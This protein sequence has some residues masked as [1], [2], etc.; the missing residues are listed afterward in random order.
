MQ[1]RR[2]PDGDRYVQRATLAWCGFQFQ[3]S[4][5]KKEPVADVF[6]AE[7][8][9]L[10]FWI[11]PFSVITDVDHKL[12]GGTKELQ[13]HIPAGGMP[14]NVLHLFLRNTEQSKF[15]FF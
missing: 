14:D 8:K 12:R 6:E 11:K 5:V 15:Q 1:R 13:S 9:A 3:F 2:L 4:V 10:R 7:A